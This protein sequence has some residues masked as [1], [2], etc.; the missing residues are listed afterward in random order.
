MF[1]E[2]AK[3]CRSARTFFPKEK[4]PRK[5]LEYIVDTARISASARNLQRVRYAIIEGKEADETFSNIGLGGA[6]KPEEKPKY[7]DRAPAYILLLAPSSD[8]DM[9]LYI[10]LGI[11]AEVIMLAAKD[12]GYSGCII[13]S[14]KS[15][16]MA[17]LV[18]SSEY[19]PVLLIALGKSGESAEIKNISDGE[20][21]NY[22]KANG[23]HIV[24]KY[25]LETVLLK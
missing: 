25:S 1:S 7:E 23:K 3:E 5:D 19:S 24:P 8:A 11:A 20:S 16:F 6:L 13:R 12:K 2:L 18:N 4:I 17:S 9:N 15:E 14:F 22:Y 10:D 21:V